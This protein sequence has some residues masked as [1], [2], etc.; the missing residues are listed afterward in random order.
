MVPMIWRR[1][2]R[3]ENPLRSTA[4]SAAEQGSAVAASRTMS[5]AHCPIWIGFFMPDILGAN[6]FRD[7]CGYAAAIIAEGY[8][9]AA[10]AQLF[11]GIPHDNRMAGELKHFY[12][13]VV[14]TDGHDL[15]AAVTAMRG[16]ALESVPLG[17]AR[18]QHVDHG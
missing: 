11:A 13:V 2:W 3:M 17:T 12:I 9:P 6:Y 7:G 10:A 14:V 5:A 1:S 16:P 15:I 4:A 8:A 18:I